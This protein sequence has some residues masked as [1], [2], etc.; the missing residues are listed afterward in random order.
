M[1]FLPHLL[2]HKTMVSYCSPP[3]LQAVFAITICCFL[4]RHC[5]SSLEKW[6]FY[7][8]FLVIK[9]WCPTVLHLLFSLFLRLLFVVF[10]TDTATPVLRNGFSTSPSWS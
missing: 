8:T 9:P 6:L 1:A 2:G 4:Y 5:K 3:P 10:S 7:L